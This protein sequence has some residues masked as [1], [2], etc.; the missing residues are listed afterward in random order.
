MSV[1]V[2]QQL[3]SRLLRVQRSSFSQRAIQLCPRRTY[4]LP[5]ASHYTSFSSHRNLHAYNHCKHQ[6]R[7]YATPTTPSNSLEHLNDLYATARDEF[8]MAAEETTKKTIYAADDRQAA[9]D[10]FQELKTAYEQAVK[11]A[12][13]DG[14]REIGERIGTRIRELEGAI[15]GL[16]EAAMEDH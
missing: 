16:E 5:A 8:E 9:F 14:G 2:F 4:T 1:R 7:T 12:G 10:A 11:E 15:K 3:P 6:H 13:P